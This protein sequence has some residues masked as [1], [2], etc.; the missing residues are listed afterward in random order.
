MSDQFVFSTAYDIGNGVVDSS[1]A[2]KSP[3]IRV[4]VMQFDRMLQDVQPRLLKFRVS[5]E[6]CCLCWQMTL[7]TSVTT[8]CVLV[9]ESVP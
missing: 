5:Y 1:S 8:P 2:T 3:S 6:M 7:R 4:A 9:T